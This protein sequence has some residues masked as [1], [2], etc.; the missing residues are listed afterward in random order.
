[1]SIDRKGALH[2]STPIVSAKLFVE[3]GTIVT[4]DESGIVK[5]WDLATGTCKKTFSN[6]A[7]G[8]HDTH[9][10]GDTLIMV[11][12]T[13]QEME[14][15]VWDVGKGKLLQKVRGSLSDLV[16]LKVSGDGSKVFG[17]GMDYIEAVSVETGEDAGRAKL[18]LG[19]GSTFFVHGSQVGI[20]DERGK[21]W[22]FGG[23]EVSDLMEFPD[24]PRFD[25]ID[26]STGRGIKAR[27][28]EDTVTKRLVFRL[29]ERYL[30]SDSEVEWDGRYL[31]VWSRSGDVLII[32]FRSVFPR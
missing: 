25:L 31:L 23:P 3:D 6:P 16:D 14:Y 29:P 20:D 4:S 26:W 27:W 1:M 11:W 10:A 21:G 13:D 15:H 8:E 19:E 28:I 17:L 18:N 5:T 2:G 32:D 9:L 7:E 12:W 22:D 24:R 30:K